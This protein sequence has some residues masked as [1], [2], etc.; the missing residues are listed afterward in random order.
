MIHC[1][2]LEG[3]RVALP[4]APDGLRRAETAMAQIDAASDDVAAE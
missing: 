3:F 2:Y 1:A 4:D